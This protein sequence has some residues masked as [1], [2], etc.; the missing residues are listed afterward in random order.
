M[1]SSL[2]GRLLALFLLVPTAELILLIWIG[3]RVGFWPT[4]G[5]IALTALVGS[6][7]ARREGVAAFRRFQKRMATG[8]LPGRELTDGLIILVAGALLLTPG[9][10]TDVVGLL[11]L[12]PPSRAWIR[13]RLQARFQQNIAQGNASL[14]VMHGPTASPEPAEG[15]VEDAT[16]IHEES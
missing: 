11:G 14:F 9:I 8:Q 6:W 5:L 2:F 13:G 10:L 16:I 1:R 12:L 4:V 3:E 15:A 7:L